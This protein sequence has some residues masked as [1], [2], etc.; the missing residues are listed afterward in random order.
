MSYCLIICISAYVSVYL[1]IYPTVSLSMCLSNFTTFKPSQPY[2]RVFICVFR[3]RFMFYYVLRSVYVNARYLT[4][5]IL[6]GGSF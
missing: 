1:S 6:I 5:A 2:K 4:D 3:Y